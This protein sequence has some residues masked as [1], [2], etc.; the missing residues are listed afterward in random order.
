M[1]A[2]ASIAA[3]FFVSPS[4]RQL[5][6]ESS[7]PSAAAYAFATVSS[8]SSVA[9]PVMNGNF[10]DFV[11]GNVTVSPSGD[12]GRHCVG[13]DSLK[14]IVARIDRRLKALG[15]KDAPAS[16]AA[17][18]SDSTIR[19][20]R[21][22]A[23]GEIAT[24]GVNARTLAAL[25]PILKT[26][27]IWLMS[28]EGPETSEPDHIDSEAILGFSDD[29]ARYGKT[30][31]V[32]G[33]VGA[34]SVAHYYALSQGDYEEVDAPAGAGD[35]TVAVEIKGKSWG[36]LMDSWLV[37]YDDVRSPVTDDLINETCVVGLADDR[38][39]IKQIRRERD[40]SFTLLS[41]SNEPPIRNV[42]IEWAAKVTGLRPRR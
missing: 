9:M 15:L 25:A 21:R 33:Y 3:S 10:T 37:F 17:K 5:T 41:N 23:K 30:V 35:Q 18:L 39:L 32:V 1:S 16:R 6:V 20:L 19:N 42:E 14:K 29:G 13:M 2:P 26:T 11:N 24:K 12:D 7:M 40:G 4:A 38:I 22:G 27:P 34:G 36:P 31:R 28:G 8:E